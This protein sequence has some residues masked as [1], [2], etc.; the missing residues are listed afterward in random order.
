MHFEA[1]QRF[2]KD[3]RKLPQEIKD[4]FKK[5]PLLLISDPNYPSLRHGKMAG[6]EDLYEFSVT[7][8]YRATY[9]KIGDI[10]YLRRIGTHDILSRP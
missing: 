5:K 9:Q 2:K 8:N 3:Y 7:M 4:L 6:F 10:G 1:T